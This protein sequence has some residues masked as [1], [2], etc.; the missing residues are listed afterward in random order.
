MKRAGG[1]T[2]IEDAKIQKLSD[3]NGGQA[4]QEFRQALAQVIENL[5]GADS[6]AGVGDLPRNQARWR[7]A[8]SLV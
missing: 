3:L 1:N 5:N 2:L 8:T 7:T 6:A 4:E